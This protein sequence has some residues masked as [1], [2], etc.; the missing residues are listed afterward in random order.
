[1]SFVNVPAGS[2]FPIQNIPFGVISTASDATPRPA[3]VIGDHAVDLRAVAEAGLF[4]GPLL[5]AVAKDVFSKPSLNAFMALG[6]PA[7]REARHTLQALL[8]ASGPVVDLRESQELQ[9][10][11]LVPLAHVTN[12]LP[13][14]IG[15]YTDFYA[16]KEHATNVGIMFR[17]KD[18]ALMPNWVHIPVG[19]H[20]RSSSVVVSGTPLHRPCGQ[21]L[22][23]ATKL[24][25]F[26]ASK[27]LD[28]ELEMA[29]FVGTGNKL[30][31]RISVKDA[32]EHIFGVVV[33]NDWSA[34]DI[35]SYEYVPLGPFLGKNF[36]TTISPWIVTLDALE[37]FRVAQPHQ[38]PAPVAYLQ[39][40]TQDKNTYDIKLEVDWKPRN[41]TEAHTIVKS[42]LKYMYW[43]F[44]QQLA[45]HTINGCNART[46]DLCGTGTISGK[47]QS[48]FGSFLELTW[49]GANPVNVKGETRTFLEDGDEII[50]RGY[51]EGLVDGQNVRIGFGEAAGAILPAKPFSG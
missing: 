43:S 51:C 34:R 26:G 38:D 3:T 16:S 44:K 1:M 4:N 25:E 36:G 24:P 8:A 46:G 28:I 22:N 29:F 10:K 27:K 2:H 33:M 15:D 50:L 12:H 5:K 31:D 41:H 19:Y 20:G 9:A 6:R 21:I 42:N 37:P 48:E 17:G 23:P 35:Q 30:G 7:W 49:N 47:D 13:A 39:D 32:E 45:H 18:N 11:I 14:E 40:P